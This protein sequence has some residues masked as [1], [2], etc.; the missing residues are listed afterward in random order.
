MHDIRH[1]YERGYPVLKYKMG[2][3]VLYNKCDSKSHRD[4]KIHSI[5]K[6]L[7]K[8]Y[9]FNYIIKTDKDI[10]GICAL[11]SELKLVTSNQLLTNV[12]NHLP[13]WW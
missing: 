4:G 5:Y 12:K 13:K 11:D 6:V 1:A 10:Y 8:T 7:D 3:V 2:D 9:F